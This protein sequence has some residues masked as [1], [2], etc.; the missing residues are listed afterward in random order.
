[1]VSID[2]GAAVGAAPTLCLHIVGLDLP[3]PDTLLPKLK[4]KVC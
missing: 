2:V 3:T 4:M 1:M